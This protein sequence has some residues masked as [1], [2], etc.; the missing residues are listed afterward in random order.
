MVLPTPWPSES[1]E[2]ETLV[3]LHDGTGQDNRPTDHLAR[4]DQDTAGFLHCTLQLVRRR[5]KNQHERPGPRGPGR[6]AR[7]KAQT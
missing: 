3:Y 1:V 5:P 4:E 7:A 2:E 6:P